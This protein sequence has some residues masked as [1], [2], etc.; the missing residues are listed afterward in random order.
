MLA[1]TNDGSHIRTALG[2]PAFLIRLYQ[3]TNFLRTK[4]FHGRPGAQHV[5]ESHKPNA[6]PFSGMLVKAPHAL[7]RRKIQG[8]EGPPRSAAASVHKLERQSTNALTLSW[9]GHKTTTAN[10]YTV[11]SNIRS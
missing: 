1:R 2:R 4:Q 5:C 8:S 3:F 7:A 10:W 9:S 11:Y 6:M